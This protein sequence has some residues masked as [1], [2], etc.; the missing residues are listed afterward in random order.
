MSIVAMLYLADFVYNLSMMLVL[1]AIVGVTFFGLSTIH[2]A[3]VDETN[4]ISPN[5]K[6]AAILAAIS[7]GLCTFIPSKQT[8]YMMAATS[9]TQELAANPKVTEM[10]D[11]VYKLL[12]EKLDEALE[13][14]K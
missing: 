5:G 4:P 7:L 13:K 3:S 12:N 6:K 14:K 1:F 2:N 8:I 11:K 9:Y 10:G